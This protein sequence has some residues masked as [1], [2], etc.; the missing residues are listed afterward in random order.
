MPP[1]SSYSADIHGETLCRSKMRVDSCMS[2]FCSAV[3]YVSCDCFVWK[4]RKIQE[5]LRISS[6]PSLVYTAS[7]W[8]LFRALAC[9]L[10]QEKV[11]SAIVSWLIV[12]V[13]TA[14]FW[15]WRLPTWPACEREKADLRVNNVKCHEGGLY[16]LFNLWWVC[17]GTE[18]AMQKVKAVFFFLPEYLE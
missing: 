11:V 3:S 1:P 16:W 4:H 9:S 14:R 12:C 8:I 10:L 17:I 5:Q 18:V 6:V 13:K 15:V 2:L 7:L